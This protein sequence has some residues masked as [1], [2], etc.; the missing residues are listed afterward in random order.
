MATRANA[1]NADHLIEIK[2]ALSSIT[3]DISDLNKTRKD[4]SITIKKTAGNDRKHGEDNERKRREDCHAGE[5][6]RG[7]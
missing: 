4:D 6:D 3:K 7:A 1:A 5:K 2:D